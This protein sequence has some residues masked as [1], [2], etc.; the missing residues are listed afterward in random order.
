[1][2]NDGIRYQ[3]AHAHLN[4]RTRKHANLQENWIKRP[5][6]VADLRLYGS[7]KSISAATPPNMTT[8]NPNHMPICI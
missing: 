8:K 3:N 1:M 4:T 5:G 6:G 7:S 2:K